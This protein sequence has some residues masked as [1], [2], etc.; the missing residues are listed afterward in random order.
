MPLLDDLGGGGGGGRRIASGGRGIG[1]TMVGG[2]EQPEQAPV[3]TESDRWGFMWVR[4]GTVVAGGHVFCDAR[5]AGACEWAAGPIYVFLLMFFNPELLHC[6]SV[7]IRCT[8][9]V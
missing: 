2:F 9:N 8:I 7:S 1:Q 3:V 5:V 4:N 6:G